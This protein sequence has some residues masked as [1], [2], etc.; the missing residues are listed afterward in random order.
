MKFN[1]LPF[2]A[3]AVICGVPAIGF[4]A[5]ESNVPASPEI[6]PAP[7]EYVVLISESTAKDK[8]WRQTA[9]KFLKRYKGRPVCWENDVKDVAQKLRTLQPRYVAVIAKPEE[10][11]RVLISE[12]HQLSRTI[13]DDIYGDF[14]WGVVT[15]R[16][17]DAAASLLAKDEPLVLDRALGTTNFDQA[18][19]QKSFFITDWGRREF[20]STENYVSS[21]KTNAKPGEEMVEIWAERWG[22]IQPQFLMSASHATEYNLEMPFGEGLI[23]SAGTDFYLVPKKKLRNFA[24]TLGNEENTLKFLESEALKKLPKSDNDKV[25]LAVGNCLFGDVLRTPQSMAVTA[26]S[27]GGVKQLVGY[28]VPSWFGEGGWGTSSKFFDGHQATSVGQ[29]W[30]FNNQILLNNMPASAARV[31]MNLIPTGMRGINTGIMFNALKDAGIPMSQKMMG[32]I[33]DRDT[34][35]FYGDPLYRTQFNPEAPSKSP[36]LCTTDEVYGKQIFYVKTTREEKYKGDF[37]LWFPKRFD[38]TQTLRV[39]GIENPPKPAILTENFVIFR[40]LELAPGETLSITAPLKKATDSK[41]DAPKKS[42][43]N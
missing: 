38:T 13:N 39:S 33:H 3:A 11:D 17:A 32:R 41:A 18:R 22:E 23:A 4:S 9:D 2:V 30:F 20:V 1:P 27:V 8:A 28:T 37:C 31:R 35:A 36:W 29:A 19:F 42:P 34:V 12:L 26:I 25:W 24:A 6:V 21:P 16:D 7:G 5:P 10:I 14:L 15:G 43:E 40:D